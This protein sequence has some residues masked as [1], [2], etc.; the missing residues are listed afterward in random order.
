RGG[1]RGL[2]SRPGRPGRASPAPAVGSAQDVPALHDNGPEPA[3]EAA[4]A[5]DPAVAVEVLA[6]LAGAVRAIT[7]GSSLD[8][9]LHRLA[10]SARDLVG[11]RYAAI[12][13]PEQEGD[14]FARFVTVGMSRSE[15]RR[16]GKGGKTR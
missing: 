16:V 15:E 13:L 1:R 10:A 11:A 9:V 12:G 2:T 6:A 14:Q 3:L 8:R 7:L 4:T 5:A